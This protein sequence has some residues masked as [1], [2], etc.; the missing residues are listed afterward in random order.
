M[1]NIQHDIANSVQTHLAPTVAR[2]T[3][4]ESDTRG[5]QDRASALE[6]E[7]KNFRREVHRMQQSMAIAESAASSEGIDVA[8]LAT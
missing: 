3:T 2:I 6:E 8:R 7:Q 1:A 4:V 5:I